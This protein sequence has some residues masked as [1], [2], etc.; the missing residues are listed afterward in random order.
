MQ[1]SDGSCW[2]RVRRGLTGATALLVLFGL[3]PLRAHAACV[4]DCSGTAGVTVNELIVMV[5]IAL[6]TE[7]IEECPGSD[8]N[9]DGKVTVNEIILGV[10]NLL[11]SCPS[12]A[13]PTP[14]STATPTPSTT[15]TPADTPTATATESGVLSIAEAAARNADGIALHLGQTVTTEGVVTV[16]AG[17][18][19]NNKL[20]IFIQDGTAGIMVYDQSSADVDAFQPGQRLR[21]TGVIRQQDPTSDNNPATGTVAV[22]ITGGVSTVLSSGNPIPDPQPVTLAVL[23]ASGAPYT[24]SLVRVQGVQKISG[25]WPTL[26]SQST[27]VT[28]SDDGGATT[29]VLRLQRFTITSELVQALNAI[30]NGSFTLTGIV[31]QNDLTDDGKLL[32]GFEIWERGAQDVAGQ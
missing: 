17:L 1:R 25:N 24:G 3:G 28:I 18:L 13:S 20:K 12:D 14:T 32:S 6:G 15:D 2:R 22:D 5:N 23:N 19:A 30:G 21:V 10:N 7:G 27:Q 8:P 26:G 16:A 29:L 11:N 31:V 4:G 9:A